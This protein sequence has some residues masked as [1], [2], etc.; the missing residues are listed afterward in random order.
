MASYALLLCMPLRSLCLR[1]IVVYHLSSDI[2]VVP[3]TNQ[4]K[5]CSANPSVSLHMRCRCAAAYLLT[6]SLTASKKTQQTSTA[7]L[8][9]IMIHAITKHKPRLSVHTIVLISYEENTGASLRRCSALSKTREA[10][11]FPAPPIDAPP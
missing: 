1:T 7:L 6:I 11:L 5:V 4:K 2:A 10:M 8:R 9:S 3:T